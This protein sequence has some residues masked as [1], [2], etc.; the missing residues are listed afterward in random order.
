M[1]PMIEMLLKNAELAN[2][3]EPGDYIGQDGLY[4]CGKCNTPKETLVEFSGETCKARTLC[5]CKAAI[6]EERNKAKAAAKEK[7]RLDEFCR[8][9][10][11]EEKYRQ[12]TFAADNGSCPEAIAAAKWYVENFPALFSENKGMIFSGSVGTG[13]TFAACCIA[14]ALIYTNR[15]VFV[16]EAA[17]LIQDIADFNKK[18]RTLE[19]IK[20]PDLLVIDDFEANQNSEFAVA[21]L[22]EIVSARYNTVKPF[23]ITT[24]LTPKEIK[25]YA[26]SISPEQARIYD[27][28]VEMC[29]CEKSP[30]ILNGKSIR[31]SIAAAKRGAK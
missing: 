2:P 14:N 26:K 24:N 3:I 7:Q 12:S 22:C 11:P 6:A 10:I 31:A 27:R 20:K 4:Y 9:C 18:D 30:V 19:D 1:L 16:R 5:H 8:A 13:K 29:T 28:A 25:D 21:K 15:R 23:I 17:S